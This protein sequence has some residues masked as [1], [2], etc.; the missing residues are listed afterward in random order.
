MD[1]LIVAISSSLYLLVLS[2]LCSFVHPHGK[3]KALCVLTW[4]ISIPLIALVKLLS[5]IF[6]G[7]PL[8]DWKNL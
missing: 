8:V 6:I 7:R 5:I 3:F 2:W 1:H 4:P